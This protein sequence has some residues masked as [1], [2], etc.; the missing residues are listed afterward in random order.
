MK[1]LSLLL[2]FAVFASLF[3]SCAPA[4]HAG[5]GYRPYGAGSTVPYDD[6]P[7][8]WDV[9]RVRGGNTRLKYTE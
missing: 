2:A 3:A 6:A 4:R 7:G 8:G 5:M 9:Y 1:C